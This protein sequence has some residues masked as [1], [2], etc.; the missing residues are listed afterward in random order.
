M[1]HLWKHLCVIF[2][3]EIPGPTRKPISGKIYPPA[4][5]HYDE[6]DYPD[7]IGSAEQEAEEEM[8]NNVADRS[9]TR[10][11]PH[12]TL[13]P[14]GGR[15]NNHVL[16]SERNDGDEDDDLEESAAGRPCGTLLLAVVLLVL[17]QAAHWL[18]SAYRDNKSSGVVLC[19]KVAIIS[20]MDDT[21][22]GGVRKTARMPT[23]WAFIMVH[24]YIQK[25]CFVKWVW[26]RR[27]RVSSAVCRLVKMR[28]YEWL[29]KIASTWSALKIMLG[30]SRLLC[31]CTTNHVEETR[32]IDWVWFV[33]IL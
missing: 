2:V 14:P 18:S 1:V 24:K 19:L 13:L 33:F 3:A 32:A 28:M 4:P 25:M 15:K 16:F 20:W 23:A 27:K 9:P 22:D 17:A 5:A 29:A 31:V 12:P 26:Q 6:E 11:G 30:L 21:N 8:T 10:G 7:Q